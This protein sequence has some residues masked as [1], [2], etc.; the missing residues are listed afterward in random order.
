MIVPRA[1]TVEPMFVP[2]EGEIVWQRRLEQYMS[3]VVHADQVETYPRHEQQYLDILG[4]STEQ[5]FELENP[6]A[7]EAR[8]MRDT[9]V[10]HLVEMV[11][12]NATAFD[13]CRVFD[14]GKTRKIGRSRAE[15]KMVA[16]ALWIKIPGDRKT[17]LWLEGRGVV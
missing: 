12:R 4:V 13:A 7:P 9:M 1:Y 17:D 5:L 8:F 6:T 16:F 11:R 10:W 14:L 3:G 2:Y 15:H